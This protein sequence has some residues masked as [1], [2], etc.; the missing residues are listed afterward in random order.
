M[1]AVLVPSTNLLFDAIKLRWAAR[2]LDTYITGGIH[3][4]QPPERTTRPYAVISSVADAPDLWTN[5]GRYD[6]CRFDLAVVTDTPEEGGELMGRILDA[7]TFAPLSIHGNASLVE[8][9]PGACRFFQERQR[10]RT[11][12]EFAARVRRGVDYNPA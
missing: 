8:V 10:R 1:P 4:D 11:V 5:V 6:G 3:W 2:S 9:R 7:L 12:Q